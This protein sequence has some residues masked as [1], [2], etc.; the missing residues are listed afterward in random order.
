MSEYNKF[1]ERT[2][3]KSQR[4]NR[5]WD[6]SKQIPDKDIKTMEQAVTQCSSKTKSCIL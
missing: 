4:C 6:L 2:I 3:A 1:L 5:N